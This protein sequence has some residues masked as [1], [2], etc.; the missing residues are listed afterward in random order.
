MTQPA[1][2]VE[3]VSKYFGDFPAVRSV[4]FDAPE[5]SI[6]ALLGRN[7]AGKTTMLEML[8]GLS[9]PSAGAIRIAGDS[10]DNQGQIGVLGHGLWLYDDLTAD[11]NLQF[12]ASLYG[13]AD[14]QS[15]IDRWLTETGLEPFRRARIS[16]YSRGMRQRLAIARAFLHDPKILL[17]DEP[18]T[19]LDDRA[20]RFLSDRIVAARDRGCSIIVCSHQLVEALEIADQV[21]LLDRGRLVYRG[22]NDEEL[23]RRPQSLYERLA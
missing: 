22:A 8:A 15:K 12:F 2:S 13:V 16:E 7:G 23:R 1:I 9:R 20:I 11:E 4:S 18:W 5:G 10:D 21:A 17:L 3:S 14:P 19:A 6:L